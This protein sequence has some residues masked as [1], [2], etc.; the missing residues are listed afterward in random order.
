MTIANARR[1]LPSFV[2]SVLFAASSIS[3][4]APS[5]AGAGPSPAAPVWHTND[6]NAE[7]VARRERRPRVVDVRADW[8]PNCRSVEATVLRD[9]RV[10]AELSR[11][12][13]TSLDVTAQDAAASRI[14]TKYDAEALPAIRVFDADGRRVA[15]TDGAVDV[16][17]LL[18]A[19]AKAK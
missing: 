1:S 19:L 10:A 9:P 14:A 16:A 3:A 12:V 13:A 7:A 2:I 8:C 18:A 6:E 5:G 15:A 17:S 11:F 4:C